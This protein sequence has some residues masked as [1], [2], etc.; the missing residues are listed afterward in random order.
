MKKVIAILIGL[1]LII[2]GCSMRNNEPTKEQMI[3]VVKS[4][5]AIDLL[6]NSLKFLEV[7]SLPNSDVIKKYDILYESVKWNP[8][9]GISIRI[10]INGDR[11][12]YINYLIDKYNGNLEIGGISLSPKLSDLLRGIKND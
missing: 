2:G 6:E 1:A 3:E 10:I 4:K 9:G 12:L 8:M 11:D 5:E 7:R